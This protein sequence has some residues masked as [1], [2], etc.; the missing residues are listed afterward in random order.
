MT[1]S[2]KQLV[3]W[4]LGVDSA[5]PGEATAWHWRTG[6]L[7]A[8]LPTWLCVLIAFSLIGGIVAIYRRDARAL[9][10]KRRW[11]LVVLRLVTLGVLFVLLLQVN[12]SVDRTALPY[13]VLMIDDSA[14]M[15]F[16]DDYA[17][18]EDAEAA[19][20]LVDP[21]TLS[22]RLEL[23]K[24]LLSNNLLSD[25]VQRY[26]VRAYRFSEQAEPLG[27]TT[28]KSA[29]EV[30]DA[31]N[32]LKGEGLE[33]LPA[34][35]TRQVLDEFRGASPT[36]MVL[37]TDGV[38]TRGADSGLQRV[39][40]LDSKN[41]VP[42]YVVGVGSSKAAADIELTNVRVDD[43]AIV[44]EPILFS[45]ELKLSG[46]EGQD[47]VLELRNAATGEQLTARTIKL[48]NTLQPVELGYVPTVP[49]E[50]D[51]QLSVV[52]PE[53]EHLT[54]NNSEVRHV[55]VRE[56]KIRVLLV[57]MLPRYEFRYLKHLLERLEG[58]SGSIELS[59]VLF[60]ADPEW[61]TLDESAARTKGRLPVTADGLNAFD[62]IILGDVDPLLISPTTQ[63]NLR[64]FVREKGGGVVLVA[65]PN[66][67]PHAYRGT[68]LEPLVP[69][70]L[71]V[72]TA[73]DFTYLREQGAT[74]EPTLSGKRGTQLFRFAE[75]ESETRRVMSQMSKVFSVLKLDASAPGVTVLAAG[76]GNAEPLIVN[77]QYGAGRVVLHATDDLWM[78]RRRAGDE[79][80]G[81][82]W[83]SLI[84]LLSRSSLIGR[85][86]DTE[87]T[88]DRELYELG[89]DV[90]FQLRFLDSRDEPPDR[91]ATVN[92]ERRNG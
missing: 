14:S 21:E 66:H 60:D 59:T 81:R 45:A 18:T 16:Q 69:A 38:S 7:L 61:N 77:R 20:K 39:A 62:V 75:S 90:V 10:W 51:Y 54:E 12:L 71:D 89:E 80:F 24:A 2:F 86:R 85:D 78:W 82:Y 46:F 29:D 63:E 34:A 70:S 65:G 31:I 53:G 33:T 40:S 87:L 56:G 9:S 36:A 28:T 91:Q 42:L 5:G 55:S 50:F 92:V 8:S 48:R 43:V 68:R 72:M 13:V 58:D 52:P 11:S 64:D 76:N 27:L 74:I 41:I 25:L 32:S 37:L 30:L 49:G 44:K 17:E 22:T 67:N 47:I 6:G 83:I 3:E 4:Y 88:T 84:R 1:S 73:A 35:A 26:R 19:S 79:Y 57:E 23:T 15:Q